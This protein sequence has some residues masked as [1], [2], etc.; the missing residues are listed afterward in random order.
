[1]DD[2]GYVGS[3]PKMSTTS[4][5]AADAGVALAEAGAAV[6][7]ALDGATELQPADALAIR[8]AVPIPDAAWTPDVAVPIA[9]P[10]AAASGVGIPVADARVEPDVAPVE[11]CPAAVYEAAV[12][13]HDN[14]LQNPDFTGNVTGW[15]AEFGSAREW[16]ARDAGHR[17]TSGALAVTNTNVVRSSAPTGLTGSR[18]SVATTLTG[19]RQCLATAGGAMHDLYVQSFIASD[20][21]SGSAGMVVTF[22][23]TA[24]C[25]GAAAGAQTGSLS[26]TVGAWTLQCGTIV[27]PAPARSMAIRLV[28]AKALDEPAV[29]VLFDDALVTPHR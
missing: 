4:T 7:P 21:D 2:W 1:V 26:V 5:V 25:S 24:D 3:S 8:D 27:A 20:Q 18:P 10:D 22:Y 29:T 23:A 15:T 17:A 12:A 28:V 13:R 6:E 11:R 16:D 9:E 14:L 19:S